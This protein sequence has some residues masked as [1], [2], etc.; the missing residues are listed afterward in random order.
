MISASTW[1]S[2]RG[3]QVPPKGVRGSGTVSV[4]CAVITAW[5]LLTAILRVLPVYLEHRT[6][7]SVMGS[8]V[9]GYASGTDSTSD[10]REALN[11]AWS[12]NRIDQ[13]DVDDVKIERLRSHIVLRLNYQAEF[14]L[15]GPVNGVWDFDE[16]E[17]DG[18]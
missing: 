5:V 12:V 1:P 4:F 13:A 2:Y 18:R 14:P 8:V 9:E 6:I 17:V 11:R 10:V 3:S 15:F 16:V 7:V